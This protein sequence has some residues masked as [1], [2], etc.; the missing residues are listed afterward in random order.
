MK[1]ILFALVASVSALSGMSIAHADGLQGAYVGAGVTASRYK[2]DVPGAVSSDDHSG[3]KSAGKLFAGY[4]F[5]KTWAVEGG[6]TDFGG[7]TYNF[8]QNGV[9]GGIHTD[10]HAFYV[11]GKATMPVS[12][13]VGVFG[14][15]G[16]AR[17]H[18]SMDGTGAAAGSSSD[19][20]SGLYASVGAQY[21]IN[22]NVS[23]T[24]EVEHFGQSAD[25]G[26]KST[27]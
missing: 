10:S 17:T 3:Y 7:K 24:A 2:F 18:D 22:K 25:Q 9:P 5:D 11:A 26:R 13:Q 6:Y 27:A 15:L 14:K 19:S 23:L 20:K 21:A 4:D 8:T 16:V 12:D 1:K